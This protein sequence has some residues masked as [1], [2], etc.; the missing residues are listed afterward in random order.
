[1]RRDSGIT[2]VRSPL[3]TRRAIAYARSSDPRLDRSVD[4]QVAEVRAAAERE[5]FEIVETFVDEGI[6][7]GSGGDRPGFNAAMRF[8]A[9]RAAELGV[10]RLYCSGRSRLGRTT[11]HVDETLHRL[12]VLHGIE[13]R[14][15]LG[16]VQ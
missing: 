9:E 14:A 15:A 3:Q 5:G 11:R 7:A 8:L 4:R 16:G 1:M 13:V 12:E 10:T 2:G 6:S